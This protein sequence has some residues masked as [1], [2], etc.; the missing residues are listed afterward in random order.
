ME[1]GLTL[2]FT[3]GLQITKTAPEG[4]HTQTVPGELVTVQMCSRKN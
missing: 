1:K 3:W 4:K 2:V